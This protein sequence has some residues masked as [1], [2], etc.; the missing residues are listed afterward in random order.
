MDAEAERLGLK[1]LQVITGDAADNE[2]E[3]EAF[4]RVVWI[5]VTPVQ[6]IHERIAG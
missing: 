1:N 5:E 3:K 2:F 4:D 6:L